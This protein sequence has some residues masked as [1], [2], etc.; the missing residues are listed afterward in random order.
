MVLSLFIFKIYQIFWREIKTLQVT[1]AIQILIFER[2]CEILLFNSDC[3]FFHG[4][5]DVGDEEIEN[6]ENAILVDSLP[7]SISQNIFTSRLYCKFPLDKK[8]IN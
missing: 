5:Q 3:L 8:Y 7:G 2:F 4:F 1:K 6:T